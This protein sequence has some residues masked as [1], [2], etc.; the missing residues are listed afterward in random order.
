MNSP[1]ERRSFTEIFNNENN[2]PQEKGKKLS[3]FTQILVCFKVFFKKQKFLVNFLIEKNTKI[4]GFFE[5]NF[6]TNLSLFWLC[7]LA[8]TVVAP[9]CGWIFY[10]CTSVSVR[11]NDDTKFLQFKKIR[12]TELNLNLPKMS[13]Q[14]F[15]SKFL[16][17]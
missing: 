11:F 7:T 17:G 6:E 16:I 2:A 12:L 9:S 8:G 14:S 15:I 1:L 4:F 3:L 10:H 5:I 13:F